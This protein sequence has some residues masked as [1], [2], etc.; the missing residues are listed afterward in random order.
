MISLQ[1]S[2][3]LPSPQPI[4]PFPIDSDTYGPVKRFIK[5]GNSLERDFLLIRCDTSARA[6]LKII[7][8]TRDAIISIP[9]NDLISNICK[10]RLSNS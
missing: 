5:S 6:V 1:I 7:K 8:N 3:V 9:P 2:T 10:I 4:Q